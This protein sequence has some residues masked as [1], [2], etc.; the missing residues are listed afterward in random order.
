MRAM[1]LALQCF[2][3][4]LAQKVF[5]TL[6]WIFNQLI[7]HKRNFCAV[8]QALQRGLQFVS[9]VSSWSY[10]SYSFCGTI[11]F[12]A[13][14]KQNWFSLSKWNFYII[15]GAFQFVLTF[16]LLVPS[17]N[18]ESGSWKNVEH[19]KFHWYVTR[20]PGLWINLPFQTFSPDADF[21]G[22]L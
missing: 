1:F 10:V 13:F 3:L 16:Q 14:L 18:T 4:W 19:V 6:V 21:H 11:L 8:Y 9:C 15:Y 22:V 12:V 2:K 17:S 20:G 7:G 5:Y